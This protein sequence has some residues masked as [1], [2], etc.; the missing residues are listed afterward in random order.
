MS[1]AGVT[2]ANGGLALSGTTKTLNARTLS[3]SG[4]ATWS[5]GDIAAGNGAIFNNPTASTF[6]NTFNGNFLFNQGGTITQFNNGGTFAKTTG[7]GVTLMQVNFS[8][9]GAV[10]VNSGTLAFSQGL[11]GTTGNVTI[12]SGATLDVSAGAN[13]STAST[14]ADNGVLVLGTNNFTISTD[15]TNA[16]FGTGNSFSPRASVQGT[17]QLL[18]AGNTGQSLTGDVIA[19]TTGT[20]TLALGNVHIGGTSTKVFAINNTGTSGPSLRGAIQTGTNGGSITD[21]RLTGSGV[22]AANFGPL[23]SGS[24]T[25]NF[26]VA[27]TG[28]S[29]GALTGQTIR[30]AH[31]AYWQRVSSGCAE[32]AHARTGVA[33]KC[34]C[35]RSRS[36]HAHDQQH[37]A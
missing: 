10:N 16:S 30:S 34:A 31:S 15:Y 37:R 6:T 29:A 22:T 2:N 36:N 28:T 26:T 9:T 25:G 19:G 7:T 5:G 33:A 3:N 17:G 35:R 12:A 11:Q 8:N 18:A 23:A 13:G 20:A 24:S 32:R 14:L 27:F 1:G 21:S 4:T